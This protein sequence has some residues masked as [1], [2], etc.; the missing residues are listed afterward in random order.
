MLAVL[1]CYVVASLLATLVLG[2]WLAA[3]PDARSPEQG[4]DRPSRG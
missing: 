1:V 3:M 2:R 4:D